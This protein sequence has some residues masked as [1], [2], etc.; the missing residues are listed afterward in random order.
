MA[1]RIFRPYQKQSKAPILDWTVVGRVKANRVALV[2]VPIHES[3]DGANKEKVIEIIRGASFTSSRSSQNK[4]KVKSQMKG[5]LSDGTGQVAL[6][7]F[8]LAVKHAKRQ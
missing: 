3:R 4:G 7:A 6:E 1:K 2:Q 8:R 5:I